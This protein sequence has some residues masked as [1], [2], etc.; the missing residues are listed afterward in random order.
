MQ[1]PFVWRKTS[2]QLNVI[3]EQ[4]CY[5]DF[6]D[7]GCDI[8]N[9]DQKKTCAKHSVFGNSI[10]YTTCDDLFGKKRFELEVVMLTVY[11]LRLLTDFILFCE[12]SLS[13]QVKL[14]LCVW[15]RRVLRVFLIP[16]KT[17]LIF[18]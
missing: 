8:I 18:A 11:C 12:C 6:R 13:I 9:K 3:S 5:D 4:F 1:A 14:S 10:G 15:E 17:T 7:V 2:I 16:I